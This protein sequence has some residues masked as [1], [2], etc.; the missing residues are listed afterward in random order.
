M[1]SIVP[2]ISSSVSGPLGIL[3]LPRLWQKALLQSFGKLAEG[4]KAI[5]PGFDHKVLNCIGVDPEA[6]RAF[7]NSARP[8]YPAFEDWVRSQPNVKLDAETI[9][10]ANHLV[11]SYQHRDDVRASM[12]AGAGMTDDGTIRHGVPLNDLDDW[13]GFHAALISDQ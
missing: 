11:L 7:I 1:K 12:L 3:H 5:G 4:Y 2:L 6:A 9:K 8:T 10:Q 13:Q